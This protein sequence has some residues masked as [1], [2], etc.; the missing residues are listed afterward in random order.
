MKAKFNG[1]C[2]VCDMMIMAG[3]HDV[4][5]DENSNW[6]HTKCSSEIK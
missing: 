6:I 4:V 3:K 5:K 1:T 2:K